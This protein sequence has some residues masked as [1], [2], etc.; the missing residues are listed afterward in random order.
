MLMN[1]R[2]F[3]IK[4]SLIILAS[5]C[6]SISWAA[7]NTE[8]KSSVTDIKFNFL[9]NQ[10]LRSHMFDTLTS[11]D[12]FVDYSDLVPL[13]ISI[14]FDPNIKSQLHGAKIY[15]ISSDFFKVKNGIGIREGTFDYAEIEDNSNISLRVSL[16]VETSKNLQFSHSIYVFCINNTDY[17]LIRIDIENSLKEKPISSTDSQASVSIE[18]MTSFDKII[19]NEYKNDI[20]A[21]YR[22]I[23]PYID[24]N[25]ATIKLKV[26][27]LGFI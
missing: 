24:N 3:I 18:K 5:L 22:N 9:Y 14:D 12:K 8:N 6:S 2:N 4:S 23:S 27:S 10:D 7:D 25:I 21:V 15:A 26:S 17:A 19:S 20:D 13:K 11:L 1:R 16:P